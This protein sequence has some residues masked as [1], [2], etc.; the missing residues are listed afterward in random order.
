[1]SPAHRSSR[2][3]EHTLW[4]RYLSST[5]SVEIEKNSSAILCDTRQIKPP[6]KS[7][8]HFRNKQKKC[9]V[10]NYQDMHIA[11]QA[12]SI[13]YKRQ[14]NT[15]LFIHLPLSYQS[16]ITPF[17]HKIHHITLKTQIDACHVKK[18][19]YLCTTE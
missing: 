5:C 13:R 16:L 10:R 1:M 17:L 8:C 11:N 12:D 7:S 18:R 15:R 3:Q 2:S 19:S 6:R 14:V 4:L 9:L